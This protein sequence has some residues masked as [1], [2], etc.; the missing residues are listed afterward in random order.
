MCS[1]SEP[2]TPVRV[3]TVTSGIRIFSDG[4][5]KHCCVCA[6]LCVYKCVC[7]NVCVPT[8]FQTNIAVPYLQLCSFCRSVVV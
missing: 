8:L 6:N 2:L 1:L 4:F 3:I 5:S 7:A